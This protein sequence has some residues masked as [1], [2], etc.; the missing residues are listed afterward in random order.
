MRLECGK[1]GRGRIE[2]VRPVK[3]RRGQGVAIRGV[4]KQSNARGGKGSDIPRAHN[5]SCAASKGL[6]EAADTEGNNGNLAGHGFERRQGET[7]RPG[8]DHEHVSE[9]QQLGDVVAHPEMDD[10]GPLVLRTGLARTGERKDCIRI[11]SPDAIPSRHGKILPLATAQGSEHEGHRRAGRQAQGLPKPIRSGSG[12]PVKAR[13]DEVCE[14]R[15]ARPNA[16][17]AP[18]P[19]T[20]R[21]GRDRQDPVMEPRMELRVI[22]V[23]MR[24]AWDAVAEPQEQAKVA[25]SREMGMV[26]LNAVV[27]AES[28]NPV[29]LRKR[30]T[31]EIRFQQRNLPGQLPG[32]P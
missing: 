12:R 9:G 20:Q 6:G 27:G 32:N 26:K 16:D 5:L 3:A 8:R 2:E 21:V 19:P 1:M 25:G 28:T 22:C 18:A 24:Q 11:D 30:P 15:A 17:A 7:F 10:P 31:G 23:Q 4:G 13:V 29:D 14:R